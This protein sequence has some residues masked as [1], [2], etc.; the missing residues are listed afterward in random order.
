MSSEAKHPYGS[1]PPVLP[2]PAKLLD[3]G[4]LLY[5][6]FCG[7]CEMGWN[8]LLSL[9]FLRFHVLQKHPKEIVPRSLRS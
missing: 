3:N 4:V 2:E 5:C 7:H 6:P 8:T 9:S 1:F